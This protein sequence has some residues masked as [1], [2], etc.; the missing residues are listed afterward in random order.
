MIPDLQTLIGRWSLAKSDP[1]TVL[2]NARQVRDLTLLTIAGGVH[3]VVAVDS[4]GGIGPKP[5]DVVSVS[6]YICGRFGTRVPLMEVLACGGIP[7]AAFDA[8]AVEMEPLGREII[9]GVRDELCA[10]GFPESFPLSGSTEDNIPTR[11]TGMGVMILG[12]V[13]DEDFRPGTS[14]RGD[15]VVCVGLPK[16]GPHDQVRFDDPTLADPARIR[17]FSLHEGVHDILPVGSKGIRHEAEE[18]ARTAGLVFVP[19]REPNVDMAKSAGPST[20]FVASIAAGV[21]VPDSL[22][23]GIPVHSIGELR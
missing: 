10:A 20:C 23:H 16:S 13:T 8:L 3:L 11:Q 9:R 1:R 14:R 17:A 12:L 4:D 7:V 19:S 22:R 5:D 2:V 6:G 15:E 21:P 18:M